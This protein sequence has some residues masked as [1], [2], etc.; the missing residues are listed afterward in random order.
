MSPNIRC[1]VWDNLVGKVLF[2]T[3]GAE[4]YEVTSTD[5]ENIHTGPLLEGHGGEE[6]KIMYSDF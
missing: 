3:Y 1:V 4:L 2:G 5:G 6:V